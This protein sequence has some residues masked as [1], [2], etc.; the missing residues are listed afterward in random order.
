MPEDNTDTEVIEPDQFGPDGPPSDG[1]DAFG[2]PVHRYPL[3]LPV[4]GGMPAC[5]GGQA[6]VIPCFQSFMTLY[7]WQ[8]F[9]DGSMARQ[10]GGI[11]GAQCVSGPDTSSCAVGAQPNGPLG[12]LQVRTDV[13]GVLHSIHSGI[14]IFS[15]GFFPQEYSV[16]NFIDLRSGSLPSIPV[17]DFE[18]SVDGGIVD[19]LATSTD[20]DGLV[21]FHD[22]D[23]GD[24]TT[25]T[26][27][28][29]SHRYVASGNFNV[30]LTSTNT[31][32]QSDSIT[33]TVAATAQPLALRD[34]ELDPAPPGVGDDAT[35]T[36]VIENSGTAPVTAITPTVTFTPPGRAV[37][38]SGAAAALAP[39]DLTGGQERTITV[40]FDPL[41]DGETFI[42]V[43]ATGQLAGSPTSAAMIQLAFDVGGSPITV[44]LTTDPA[45][46]DPGEAFVLTADVVN[47]SGEDLEA[48]TPAVSVDPDGSA[49]VGSAAP[50]VHPTLPEGG[51]VSFTWNVT[52][53]ERSTLTVDVDATSVATGDTLEGSAAVTIGG[54]AI[55]SISNDVTG[56]ATGSPAGGQQLTI[57]GHGFDDVEAV[58]FRDAGGG[59]DAVEVAVTPDSDTLIHVQSPEVFDRL[60]TQPDGSQ[61]WLADV[62][63]SS[64]AAG[65]SNTEPFLFQGPLIESVV[66]ETSGAARTSPVGGDVI[67]VT[68]RGFTGAS[69]M[70]FREVGAPDGN[71][72]I[73]DA[74]TV[75]SD[76]VMRLDPSPDFVSFL[77]TQPDGS[78]AWAT[79]IGVAMYIPGTLGEL[80]YSNRL[81]FT[82]EGP[83]VESVVAETSGAARTSPVGGDV[84]T[85]TGRGF[86]G[87][88]S[89][90]F[91]EVGAPDGNDFIFDAATVVSDT[92]MRLD[93]SPD[94]VSFL[95]TQ[96][97]GSQAWATEIGVAMY[98]PGTLGELL[99]SNRLPFTFEGPV[100]E[101]VV[102][103][104]SGAAR[105]SP[106]GGD[107]ITVT[108]RGFTGASSMT[109]REV[110]APD[111]NDFIFDAATV[112]SDTVMRLDPSPDF[113]SFLDTQPDGSQAWATEIGVAMYIPGTLGELLYSNRLPFTFEGPVIESVTPVV[114]PGG[115]ELITVTGRG[116]T[117]SSGV[118]FR[119]VGGGGADVFFYEGQLVSDTEMLVDSPEVRDRLTG[120]P[121][122]TFGWAAELAV[123]IDDARAPGGTLISNRMPV[124]FQA[125][126]TTVTQGAP[127]GSTEVE[128]ASNDG[129]QA[130]DYAQLGENGPVRE[131]AG[132]GSLIFSAPIPSALGAGLVIT[133][134]G[135]P[136]GDTQPPTIVVTLP[137][138]GQ[139]FDVGQVV[140]AAATCTDSGVGVEVCEVGTLDTSTPGARSLR[141]RAWDHNGN[142]SVVDVPYAVGAV[143]GGLSG[144]GSAGPGSPTLIDAACPSGS[145]VL[146]FGDVAPDDVHRRS[147]ACVTWWGLAHGVDARH[148]WPASTLSRAQAASLFARILLKA[149]VAPTAAGLDRFADDDGSVHEAAIDLLA[150]LG[151][152]QG[153]ADGTFVPAEELTRGE[154]VSLLVQVHDLLGGNALPAGSDAFADDNG[155]VHEAALNRAA[156]AGLVLGRGDGTVGDDEPV[157]RAAA[158]TLIARLLARLVTSGDLELPS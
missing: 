48:V 56:D 24:G 53:P 75:V 126:R 35:A 71:D 23:F 85:V 43:G 17:A 72:F 133:E 22:W 92:V 16:W 49:T 114:G 10:I 135:P 107:V 98:I 152:V 64:P 39:F 147:V 99:Y 91:R 29:P 102:A 97:D 81:P 125:G 142:L 12:Y 155:S 117:G 57:V 122:G 33:Q 79:E 14:R 58:S 80:L 5:P 55:E 151:V 34:L 121:D 129:W 143:S 144:T 66:A 25:G 101:S 88:S 109:F 77:D 157:S 20:P 93:P 61:A 70:T 45:R 18:F 86:T 136:G 110:G 38:A 103:E 3:S 146:P 104:T 63:V 116:F 26:G 47:G 120:Q 8:E 108:G 87:A 123:L 73:F 138:A 130:G 94:F 140:A 7:S 139:Q 78:Q 52:V 41:T 124:F 106:V 60:T 154:L 4:P 11:N 84:I 36:F 46:P 115:G 31:D 54:A 42:G 19:F 137:V 90:T 82:F 1:T 62:T 89:M 149:G 51:T 141:V 95:D 127:A 119:T 30:T 28:N 67:T 74:A 65:T 15:G 59:G 148:F 2:R 145:D 6:V 21:L 112:V 156:M 131:V 69:S 132:L 128:V 134:V 105:T 96:P 158:A 68:G 76:T 111:G 9:F 153:R 83:V 100:V 44:R 32:Q 118:S 113:V 40:P 150:A 27:S 13:E 50:A 37:L